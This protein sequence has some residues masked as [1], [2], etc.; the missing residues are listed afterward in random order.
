VSAAT[1][2]GT[3]TQPTHITI[4][5]MDA[6]S[7]A[8]ALNTLIAEHPNA[9]RKMSVKILKP[10]DTLAD[11][12]ILYVGHDSNSQIKE[13]LAG[14][15][16]LPVLTVTASDGALELGSIINFVVIDG[17]IKFEISVIQATRSGLKIS[18]RLLGIAQKID[19]GGK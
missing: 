2:A 16:N 14:V 1:A 10:S 13:L 8:T 19:T 17:H 15:R 4:G 12:Q 6:D 9:A 11:I 7:V 18:S 5:V 3:A